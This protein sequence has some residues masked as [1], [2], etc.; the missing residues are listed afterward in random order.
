[1]E[2]T[3]VPRG[4]SHKEAPRCCDVLVIGGGSAGT[5]IATLL[6]QTGWRGASVEGVSVEKDPRLRIVASLLP[7]NPPI[8]KRLGA[9]EQVRNIGVLT[10]RRHNAA[11]VFDGGTTARDER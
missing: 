5:A 9:L 3:T 4:E 1:M 10:R 7:T 2:S 11:L 8:F 6:T